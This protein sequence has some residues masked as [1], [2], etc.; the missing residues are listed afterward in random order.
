MPLRLK[1]YFKYM[2]AFTGY[3]LLRN[4]L[5]NG[6]IVY[7]PLSHTYGV[8]VLLSFFRWGQ[9]VI[10]MPQFSLERFVHDIYR[11]KVIICYTLCKHKLYICHNHKYANTLGNSFG[12]CSI[13][14]E[15]YHK[16]AV[17]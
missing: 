15:K 14:A 11:Y 6:G 1:H 8:I 10:L 12:Q 9:K 2:T 16:Y 7:Q 3:C 13:D 17:L 4:H 5:S